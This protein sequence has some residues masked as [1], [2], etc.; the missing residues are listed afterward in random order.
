MVHHKVMSDQLYKPVS[1]EDLLDVRTFILYNKQIIFFHKETG[2]FVITAI[3]PDQK[4]TYAD[5]MSLP[6]NAPFQLIEGELIFMP[7]S[8]FNHPKVLAKLHLQIGN[9]IEQHKLGEVVFAPVDVCFDD[10]S[11]VQPD[12]LFVAINR[13]SI[14]GKVIAGAPDFIVEILS[15]GNVDTDKK[16][17]MKLYGNFG[18]TEYWIVNPKVETVEVY[19]N[20]LSIM[21][22]QQTVGRGEKIVS[23]AI[24]G[25][26]LDVDRI[27]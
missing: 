27:F 15:Q 25:F 7:A 9:Y 12:L 17:K 16:K 1:F 13:C 21:V 6:E 14:I 11:V 19:Y 20:I 5:Y 26:S 22:K 2:Q 23:K 4:Y 10:N 3:S 8:S 18:V 24:S